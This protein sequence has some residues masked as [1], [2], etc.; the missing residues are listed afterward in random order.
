[1]FET[2]R[3][4]WAQVVSMFLG[5]WLMAAPAVLGYGPPAADV[6]RVLG[7]VAAAFALMA[8]WGHMRPLRWMNLLF[9][10]LL[11]VVPFVFAFGT[12]ATVNS[13]AIGL[14]LAGLGFVRGE[15]T[16]RYGGGWSSLWTGQTAGSDDEWLAR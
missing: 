13:V 9:G 16:E 5:L 2:V 3:N 8:I 15:V 12:V 14:V 11:V 10:G 4:A 1:M 6:H 7:P